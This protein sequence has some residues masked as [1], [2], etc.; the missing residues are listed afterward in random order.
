MNGKGHPT[1]THNLDSSSVHCIH[2][3]FQD[4]CPDC[5]KCCICGKYKDI[6]QRWALFRD[7][8]DPSKHHCDACEDKT[9]GE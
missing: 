5:W 4:K 6:S 1:R 8:D 2:D 3:R 7:I 9:K